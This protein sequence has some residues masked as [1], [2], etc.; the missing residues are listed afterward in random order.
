MKMG[1]R[2]REFHDLTGKGT[3][4]EDEDR[5]GIVSK[6]S[7][8]VGTREYIRVQSRSGAN[9]TDSSRILIGRSNDTLEDAMHVERAAFQ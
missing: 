7:A 5:A 4:T 9:S 1:S 3:A 6:E 8:N 2:S